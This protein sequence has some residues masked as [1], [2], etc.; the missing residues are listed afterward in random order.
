MKQ[1]IYVVNRDEVIRIIEQQSQIT[2]VPYLLE[3]GT[4]TSAQ[5]IKNAV[6]TAKRYPN[7]TVNMAS[8]AQCFQKFYTTKM[9]AG[10]NRMLDRVW[11]LISSHRE[12]LDLTTDKISV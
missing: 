1:K 11:A 12:A 9:P 8:L 2:K 3:W 5:Q 10:A 7:N 4:A 6:N